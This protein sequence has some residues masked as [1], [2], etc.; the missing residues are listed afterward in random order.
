MT[1]EE[2]E[3][4]KKALQEAPK[5]NEPRLLL[6][7]TCRVCSTR[8]HRTMSKHAYTNGIVIIECPGCSNRH[9]IADHLGW[10]E[11]DQRLDARDVEQMLAQRGEPVHRCIHGVIE[12][13]GGEIKSV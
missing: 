7:Y 9:L 5:T 8:S 6:G 12:V 3:A 2:L 4:I 10:F 1:T 11:A 13:T